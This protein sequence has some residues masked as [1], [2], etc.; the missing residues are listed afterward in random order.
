MN[1]TT[2][3]KVVKGERNVGICWSQRKEE[4]FSVSDLLCQRL[5]RNET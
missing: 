1:E 3:L 5:M 4:R 2:E